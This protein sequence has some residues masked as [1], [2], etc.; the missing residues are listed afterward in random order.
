MPAGGS[1]VGC[2]KF[3]GFE[4]AGQLVG[5]VG[6]TPLDGPK[7]LNEFGELVRFGAF[8]APEFG[9]G[10]IWNGLPEPAF[11][12][13]R[14]AARAGSSATPGGNPFGHAPLFGAGNVG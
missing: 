8:V 2:P 14:D 9:P 13:M 4:L 11:M 3:G 7:L 12:P 1:P 10:V 5:V 6:E